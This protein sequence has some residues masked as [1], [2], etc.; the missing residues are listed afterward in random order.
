VEVAEEEEEEVEADDWVSGEYVMFNSLI[1]S[2]GIGTALRAM[3][4]S[5]RYL[6]GIFRSTSCGCVLGTV[7]RALA[8]NAAL[9]AATGVAVVEEVV[10]VVEE[11]E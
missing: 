2:A 4:V 10:E 7:D 3:M 1:K 6:S 11:E 9:G 8:D 5:L